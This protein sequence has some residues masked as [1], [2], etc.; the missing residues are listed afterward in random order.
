MGYFI[1]LQGNYYEGDKANRKH[2][3]VSKRP[4]NTYDW[5]GTEWIQTPEKQNIQTLA[6][7]LEKEQAYIR[8]L[9]ELIEILISKGTISLSD[10]DINAQDRHQFRRDR[11]N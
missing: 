5:N 6:E 1:D 2:T 11:R 8:N 7:I 4:D 3:E 9:E 10:F